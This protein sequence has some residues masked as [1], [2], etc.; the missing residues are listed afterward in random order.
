M[1]AILKRTSIELILIGRF[2][3]LNWRKPQYFEIFN[4]SLQILAKL[5]Y[6]GSTI[7]ERVFEYSIMFED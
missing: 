7:I 5:D 4:R 2:F 1:Q 3:K 6:T